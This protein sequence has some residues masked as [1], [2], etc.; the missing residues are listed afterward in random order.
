[1]HELGLC[2]GLLEVTLA[3]AGDRPIR[4]VRV[5]AGVTHGVDKASMEQAFQIVAMGT[6]AERATLDL[7]TVPADL[8]CR[9][10]GQTAPTFDVIALCPQCHS[11]DVEI[12]GGD[13][14]VL[15]SIGYAAPA[16]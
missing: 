9:A 7:V 11:D 10:C 2:E 1:M 16:P 15:E 4:Q 12:S 8:R 13:E 14:L 6:S 3:R 5:R